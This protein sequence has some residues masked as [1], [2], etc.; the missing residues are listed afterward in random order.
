[1]YVNSAEA[2]QKWAVDKDKVKIVDCR[3]M[4]EYVYVGH[5]PMAVSIPS[6]TWTGKW[7][8]EKKDAAL[9]DNPDFLPEIKKRFKLDDVIMV[10]CRSGHRSAPCVEVLAKAGFKN[11]F[12]IVDGFEGDKVK[13]EESYFDGKRMKNG[14]KNSGAPWTYDVKPDLTPFLNK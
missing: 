3:T 12:H 13:D 14:W 6:K 5:A 10:M 7:D 4:E 8:V 2:F 1:L 11:V 9:A